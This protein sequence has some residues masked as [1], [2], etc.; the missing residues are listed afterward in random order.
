MVIWLAGLCYDVIACKHSIENEII[1]HHT[2]SSI[3]RIFQIRN[4][5]LMIAWCCEEDWIVSFI[6]V[7]DVVTRRTTRCRHRIP[8]SSNALLNN[9]ANANFVL[10]FVFTVKQY[11]TEGTRSSKVSE[12]VAAIRNR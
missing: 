12:S 7:F 10:N 8:P 9:N 11:F 2:V 3:C 6:H 1:N 5:L 4:R